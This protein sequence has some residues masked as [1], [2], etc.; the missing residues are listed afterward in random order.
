MTQ[1]Y[2]NIE[3][4][5][6]ETVFLFPKAKNTAIS[7]ITCEFRLEDKTVRTL[8]TKIDE[9]EKAEEKYEDAV[10]KG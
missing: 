5:S 4:I 3:N 2:V 1:H 8:E 7:K 10:S 6:L 9:R